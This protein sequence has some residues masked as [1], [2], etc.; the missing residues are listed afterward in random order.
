G[1]AMGSP[2]AAWC[3][4]VR[5]DVFRSVIM[6]SAPFAGPPSLPFNTV[7]AAQSGATASQAADPIYDQLA[8]LNPPRKH[9]QKYYASREANEN[10]W[11]AP[12]GVHAFLRAYY[13]MKSADWKQ[14]APFPLEARTATEWAKLPRYY[15]MELNKGMAETVAPAMP[16]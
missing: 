8:N 7:G 5:P 6:L 10:M 2:L 16:S 12:Q 9:Y 14:N 3:S 15:I 4:L 1:H 11:H 13:H